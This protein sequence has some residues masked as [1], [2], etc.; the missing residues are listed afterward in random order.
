MKKNIKTGIAEP[1]LQFFFG[2]KKPFLND[3]LQIFW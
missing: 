3:F 2:F 1:F